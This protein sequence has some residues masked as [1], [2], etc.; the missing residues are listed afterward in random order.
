MSRLLRRIRLGAS[1]K[2][3]Q[4]STPTLTSPSG[5][6]PLTTASMG[7][8]G[9]GNTPYLT[10]TVDMLADNDIVQVNSHRL[11]HSDADVWK[12]APVLS[13]T[14]KFEP[15]PDVKNIMVT[16]GAGFM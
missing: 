3:V 11:H 5:P 1:L 16:G 13:G 10:G 15:R 9:T 14:T 4:Q 2:A 12:H 8:H 6:A 7:S